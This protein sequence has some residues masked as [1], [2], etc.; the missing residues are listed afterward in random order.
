M[1][2]ETAADRLSMVSAD[3]FGVTAT[4]APQPSGSSA[5]IEGIFDRE[6]ELVDFDG[7]TAV[8]SRGPVFMC[9]SADVEATA[10]GGRTGDYLTVSGTAYTIRIIRP[11]GTGMTELRLE[12]Q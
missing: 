7:D 12:A 10:N 9:R 11:D 5:S 1:A 4:Y 2:V 6:F 3:D 8:A